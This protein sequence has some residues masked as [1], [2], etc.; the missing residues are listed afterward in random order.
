MPKHKIIILLIVIMLLLSVLIYAL[1]SNSKS[2]DAQLNGT[3]QN[4]VD[5]SHPVS[6]P[7]ADQ[8]PMRY[9]SPS[10]QDTAVNCQLQLTPEHGLRVTA[11]TRD[12]FEYFLSQ[13]GEIPLPHI[14]QG[15]EAYITANYPNP[16]RLDI[17][18][19]WQ[20]YLKYRQSLDGIQ[21]VGLNQDDPQYFQSI[22][23]QTQDLRKRYFSIQ[24]SDAL[25]GHEN[26][27]HAYTIKRLSIIN[28][29]QL[30]SIEKAQQLKQLFDQLPDELKATLKQLTQLEDLQRLSQQIKSQNGSA[31]ELHQMRSTLVGEAAT[32]R[33]E[34]LDLQRL[35]WKQQVEQ[36]LD[37]KDQINQSGLSDA[38]KAK[39]IQQ[40]R[41][42]D[43]SDPAL[44][45]RLKTYE[46]VH[47]QG[48]ALPFAE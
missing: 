29:D 38:A 40:L 12:C 47:Q 4:A 42:R 33:L 48:K 1:S 22:F 30:S 11:Q 28:N 17:L 16:A 19:L 32:L 13:V 2:S 36:F 43:F 31:E 25:F 35:S 20:R 7:H 44:Q 27:Y 15:F 18:D 6:S 21:A 3:Q 41:D 46:S 5:P 24:E 14:Q 23:N 9:R 8:I 37:K 26:Q 10:Q 34:K 39:A 45:Q